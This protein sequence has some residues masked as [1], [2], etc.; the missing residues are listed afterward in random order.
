MP[1]HGSI[2]LYIHGNQKARYD[3]QP[4]TA[5]ST[6]T[7]LLNY[8]IKVIPIF[9][10]ITLCRCII[11]WCTQN[12]RRDDSNFTRQQPCNTE[13]AL[14]PL[15]LIFKTHTVKRVTTGNQWSAQKL[16]LCLYMLPLLDLRAHLEM[17]CS[18][19]V[20]YIIIKIF[21]SQL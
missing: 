1:K 12:I 2:I 15:R 7:Q 4:R 9:S 3:G 20:I 16:S 13:T 17:T 8:D 6:L 10:V 11:V 18:I 5:T 19:S 14:Q 21:R